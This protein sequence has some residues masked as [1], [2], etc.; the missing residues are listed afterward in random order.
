MAINHVGFHASQLRV[1]F[2]LVLPRF[3]KPLPKVVA[4]V[5]AFHADSPMPVLTGTAGLPLRWAFSRMLRLARSFVALAGA[6]GVLSS[7]AIPGPAPTPTNF[8]QTTAGA[9]STTIPDGVCGATAS[10]TGGAGASNQAATGATGQGG[11]GATINATYK[12]L[13]LQAVT[14]NVAAG[15]VTGTTAAAPSSGGTGTARGGDGGTIA[16]ATIHKGGGGGGSSS[17]SVGGVKLIE[18]GGGGGGGAAHQAAGNGGGGG[19]AGIAGATVVAGVSGSVGWQGTGTVG[20][21]QAGQT[22]AHGTGG[23]NSTTPARNGAAGTAAGGGNGGPDNGTDSG[24]G[25]GGGYFSGGGGAATNGDSSTGGGGGGGA[26][27]RSATSPTLAAA[28]PTGVSG[29][30]GGATAV[31][32]TNG[33]AGSASLNWVLCNYTLAVSKSASPST[34]NAGA[35]TTWTIAVQ[36]IGTEAMTRGDTIT[37]TDL[38]PGPAGSVTPPYKVTSISTTPGSSDPNL[39]TGPLSCTGVTVG[40]T[41][42]T[43]TTCSRA[44][45]GTGSSGNPSSG[46][47]GLNANETLTITYEQIIPNTAAC[48]TITNTASAADR[49]GTK[50]ANANLTINCYD[51][52]ITKSVSPTSAGAGNTLTWTINVTN[53]G[54]ANMTGPDETASNPLVVSDTAPSANVSPP[55]AFTSSGPAGSCS[56]ASN[57]ITCPSGLASGQTQTFTFQQT[58]NSGTAAG[59]VISNTATVSDAKTGDANDSGTASI[60]TGT[61]LTLRK[62][63]GAN[64]NLT[65]IARIPATAGGSSNT[66]Q[67]DTAAGVSGSS[68]TVAVST[69]NVITLGAETFTSGTATNYK[70]VLSCVAGSG[71]TANALSG[72]NG[73]ASNTLVIGAGDVGKAIVCTYTNTKLPTLTLTK[74][75]SDGVGGFTFSG[76][77]PNGNGWASQT[78]TTVTSGTGVSGATQVLADFST[79]TTIRETIPPGYYVTAITCTGLGSGGTY[80]PTLATGTVAFDAAATAPGSN[81]ACTYRNGVPAFA[82][83]K[84]VNTATIAAPATLT[85]TIS[86]Q[87]TGT[88]GLTGVSV[89]DALV[90]GASSRTPTSG[91]SY[92]SGDGNS[93]SVLDAGE[94]WVYGATYVVTQ[95]NI[96]VGT[97]FSNTATAAVSQTATTVTSAAATTAVT[98]TPALTILK[99]ANTAGPVSVGQV[100]TYTFKVTNSGNVTAT[101]VT[102]TDSPFTGNGTPPVPGSE[103]LFTDAAPTGDSSDL[104]G[105]NGNWSVLAPGDA[106]TY[107]GTY[108]VTQ[109]DI[110]LLQ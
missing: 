26:S 81:I 109:A 104:T 3:S 91:P 57:T 64:P 58:I 41:M 43:S 51:L 92:S 85:Y 53:N 65:D 75:S 68:N 69:G 48:Q 62:V 31:G 86:V 24:G 45:D 59:T 77:A 5:G 105:N 30:T 76:V 78:I 4:P 8:S 61:S 27:F 99:T 17:V 20:A 71:A 90:Q 79:A 44:Y 50:S 95:A 34:V 52:A 21:G 40:S 10:I 72:S 42:P 18:A 1:V 67:F 14:G 6:T 97:T 15:G 16:S 49:A 94:T 103:A 39:A 88:V 28:A 47:R 37:L 22:A 93:N 82:V 32:V 19:S 98:R 13:P 33:V 54:P 106:I 9:I 46:T 70:T 56:Y 84:A 66:S 23:V 100:I 74:I 89:T 73:Q 25:G 63:W 101:N 2:S 80:T 11:G 35:K 12:V 55:T 36:N 102:V 38:L 7:T 96:D 110:D 29:A 83:S 107:T 108:T 60:T 87:N